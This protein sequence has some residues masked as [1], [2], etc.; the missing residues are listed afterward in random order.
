[1]KNKNKIMVA[2]ATSIM[3]IG[4]VAPLASC[5]N[6]TFTQNSIKSEEDN[7][8]IESDG[9]VWM[10]YKKSGTARFKAF[11]EKGL[12]VTNEVVWK[13]NVPGLKYIDYGVISWGADFTINH[14][15]SLSIEC[16]KYH[17]DRPAHKDFTIQWV[18]P[19]SMIYDGP[20]EFHYDEKTPVV[21]TDVRGIQLSFQDE[22]LDPSEYT[23][24]IINSDI[25][26]IDIH[27]D[28]AISFWEQNADD[29]PDATAK[30]QLEF[31]YT[32]SDG[33]EFDLISPI[34]YIHF[35]KVEYEFTCT[36]GWDITRYEDW[37]G[38]SKSQYILKRN[39]V[40]VTSEPNAEIFVLRA[41]DPTKGIEELHF[42]HEKKRF[43]WDAGCPTT[44]GN[45][46]V[47]IKATYRN[48]YGQAY[49]IR[50]E[51][52]NY[53]VD[54]D[55][56]L[57]SVEGGCEEDNCVEFVKHEWKGSLSTQKGIELRW[58]VIDQHCLPPELDPN[59]TIVSFEARD[60]SEVPPGI[61]CRV[62]KF[63][64]NKIKI[65]PIIGDNVI[66]G[67]YKFK[68]NVGYVVGGT[69][70]IVTNSTDLTLHVASNNLVTSGFATD[71]GSCSEHMSGIDTEHPWS[72]H[73]DDVYTD[74]VA[75]QCDY[76]LVKM[77]GPD[78]PAEDSI[79]IKKTEDG[80]VY[81]A[82]KENLL[83]GNYQFAFN[84]SYK[85]LDKK[86]YTVQSS[87]INLS[88]E[89][90][91][92]AIEN[93]PASISATEYTAGHDENTLK[94]LLKYGSG[95]VDVTNKIN[96]SI[97]GTDLAKQ[98][99]SVNEDNQIAWDAS[100]NEDAAPADKPF[101]L[102]AKYVSEAGVEYEITSDGIVANTT[103][104]EFHIEG[105]STEMVG[106]AGEVGQAKQAWVAK[107]NPG[108]I[109]DSD[110]L[111]YEFVNLPEELQGKVHFDGGIVKWDN[112]IPLTTSDKPYT[113]KVQAK[114][115]KAGRSEAYVSG[116]QDVK[117]FISNNA[118]EILE[119]KS[120]TDIINTINDGGLNG[121]KHML[122]LD[123]DESTVGLTKTIKVSDTLTY[124]AKIIGENHDKIDA[125]HN[126]AVTFEIQELSLIGSDFDK[127][128]NYW[129]NNEDSS[130]LRNAV[131]EW[132]NNNLPE[133]I[134]NGIKKVKKQCATGKD[135]NERKVVETE[136]TVWLPSAT[137]LGATADDPYVWAAEGQVYDYY[138]T[139][140]IAKR[141]KGVIGMEGLKGIY[142]T[143]SPAVLK[144]GLTAACAI[145]G[146]GR[147]DS[148]FIDDAN[149]FVAPCFCL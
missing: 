80:N 14:P 73:L 109:T 12:D 36:D 30:F 35:D 131:L 60:G 98:C 63:E 68:L 133:E 132:A 148:M 114:L 139:D 45:T 144:D 10:Q 97:D 65:I 25:K 9:P 124:T 44:Y 13:T 55:D 7:W 3:S 89:K 121:L 128:N 115:N 19:L 87:P 147:V 90:A 136:E 29:F 74:E 77:S 8:I 56:L 78:L 134:R 130:D 26:D 39:G 33:E 104:A 18:S 112:N 103:V 91:K 82:W 118:Q 2:A 149:Q 138:K 57:L 146:N 37:A 27:S 84:V 34:F 92:L 47:Y 53:K 137:E 143:R 50:S 129:Y 127:E 43:V 72:V 48:S 93:V 11:N 99:F 94:V 46:E 20:T 31:K 69:K 75:N 5:S 79:Y 88:I 21:I 111:T 59:K 49:V 52:F 17:Y 23:K 6:K 142:W 67:D 120:W 24:S 119:T 40:D 141:I 71:L 42:D 61:T 140:A 81:T 32:S 110:T 64:R 102:I 96:W 101:K 86:T 85:Y 58:G 15:T 1:M 122:W 66:A 16:Y 107:L 62:E 22:I 83:P 100:F 41:D 113:F 145:Y 125:E 28:G 38:E 51:H 123:N 108:E 95:D 117:L 54:E 126:A 135:T 116:T 106:V 105:G 76:S 4:L 70:G